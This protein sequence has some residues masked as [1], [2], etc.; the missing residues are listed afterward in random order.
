MN[1]KQLA[2]EVGWLGI[3]IPGIFIGMVFSPVV[4]SIATILTV[5]V[6]ILHPRTGVNR[7]WLTHLPDML[8]SSLFWGLAGLYLVMLVSIWQTED[9][10]YLLERL[11]IKIPLL[12]LPIAWAGTWIITSAGGRRAL[13]FRTL[14]C[15]FIGVVLAG[16]LV[17][18]G[19]HF[20]EINALIV[21]GQAMPVPRNNHIR[22]S[23]LVAL[24]AVIGVH[25][26]LQY[27]KQWLLGLGGCLFVGLHLLAVRS[28]LAT[29]Y[30]GMGVV[31]LWRA[32]QQGRY[33]GL[34]I[35]LVGLC[36]L[37]LVA[38][39]T[40][41]TFRTK[42]QYMRYE[43]LHRDA[44]QDTADY[45]DT[46][47]LTSIR[48]GL[49]V[50]QE[51]PLLGVGYGNLRQAMDEQYAEALPGTSGKRPHNQFVSA[52]AAGGVVGCAITIGCFLLIGFGGSR[53][54]DPLF[55]ALWTVFVL[56]CLVENTLETSAGV[57]L[58]TLVMLLFG[59]PPYR[60]PG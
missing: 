7:R 25:S 40:V 9:W 11:R 32:V 34:V 42:L 10:S 15:A 45:S 5:I 55:F 30:A 39:L 52:L 47:R 23:L 19:L 3:G 21:K 58:F 31:L 41:P 29:A 12:L 54:R 27:R 37:P 13:L 28:G 2:R 26:G 18:Y 4:L 53:W 43:L 57:T 16:V 6:L 20:K 44:T 56:S 22:F 46:G 1:A 36:L 24:A 17:N 48:L 14:L 8:R 50:W 51:H 35:G 49:N 59:Y 60:K 38:Y 33:R